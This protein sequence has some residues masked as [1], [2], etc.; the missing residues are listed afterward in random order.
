[1]RSGQFKR[2]RPGASFDRVSGLTGCQHLW[3][4]R[5]SMYE[6]ATVGARNATIIGQI[7]IS[8]YV[9]L[10]FTNKEENN[11][12]SNQFPFYIYSRGFPEEDFPR[13]P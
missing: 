13:P 2:L 1:M 6:R 12:S 9:V 3:D 11:F 7:L 10:S 4:P 5:T 8:P